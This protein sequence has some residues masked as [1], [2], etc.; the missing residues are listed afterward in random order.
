MVSRSWNREIVPKIYW[1][2]F[3]VGT[4]MFPVASCIK[5]PPEKFHPLMI[6]S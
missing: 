2:H 4:D 5:Q 3:E 1:L 6:P